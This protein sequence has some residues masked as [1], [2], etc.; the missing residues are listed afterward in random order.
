MALARANTVALVG[1][2]TPA[3]DALA[4]L[5]QAGRPD[6]GATVCSCM[7]VGLNTLKA[8]IADGANSV[9]A[10]GACTGAGTN[11]GSCRPELSALLTTLPQAF[12]AE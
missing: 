12:A 7:S 10:L 8:A 3:I 9:E 4:G 11:C 1:T 2:E 6:P 5:P